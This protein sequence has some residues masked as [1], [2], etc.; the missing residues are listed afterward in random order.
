MFSCT[1]TLPDRAVY[2]VQILDTICYIQF[3]FGHLYT[4]NLQPSQGERRL[5]R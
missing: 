3:N 2:L 5:D 4:T 1:P